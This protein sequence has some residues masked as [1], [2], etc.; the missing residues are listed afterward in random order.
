M[1]AHYT[2][3]TVRLRNMVAA[4]TEINCT[5]V[6]SLSVSSIHFS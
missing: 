3:I 1:S 2:L 6:E 4:I 5:Y